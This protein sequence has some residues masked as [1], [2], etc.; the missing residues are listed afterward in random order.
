MLPELA[1]LALARHV[2]YREVDFIAL[3][4]FNL[5]AY[6]GRHLL[7]LVLGWFEI[8]DH[9]RLARVIQT[10]NN[11]LRLLGSDVTHF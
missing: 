9:G 5:E 4:C 7:L 11:D 3:E 8:V 10:Y 1:I 6:G 2:K